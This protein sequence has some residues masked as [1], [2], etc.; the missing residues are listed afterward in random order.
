MKPLK[1][2]LSKTDADAEGIGFLVELH[3]DS[4]IGCCSIAVL[5]N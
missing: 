2:V 3:C 5:L 1:H 4:E